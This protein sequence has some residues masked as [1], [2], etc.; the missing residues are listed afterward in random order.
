MMNN[1]H[2]PVGAL[3]KGYMDAMAA[4]NKG[5]ADYY[6]DQWEK[7]CEKLVRSEMDTKKIKASADEPK[8]K[9]VKPKSDPLKG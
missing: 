7:L 3:W 2:D 4:D 5:D 8:S 6:Y 9:K 1:P